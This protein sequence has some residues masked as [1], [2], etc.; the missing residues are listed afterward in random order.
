VLAPVVSPYAVVV[1]IVLP[2]SS[3]VV[4]VIILAPIALVIVVAVLLHLLLLQVG[5]VP[6]EEHLYF[7]Q[8]P[9]R[10]SWHIFA[11]SHRLL[12]VSILT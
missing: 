1:S 6:T 5:Q 10:Y 3:V 8:V 9:L 11:F 12:R 2:S 7:G 4:P